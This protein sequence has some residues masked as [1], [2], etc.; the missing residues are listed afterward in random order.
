MIRLLHK[1][2]S[3]IRARIASA[4]PCPPQKIAPLPF[5]GTA[6][7]DAPARI[8]D[9]MAELNRAAPIYRPSK[10]W[11]DLNKINVDQLLGGGFDHFKRTLNQ[12]YFNWG[13][14]SFEDNQL[15][16]LLNHWHAAPGPTPVLAAIEGDHRMLNMFNQDMLDN[17]EKAR[18]YTFFVGLLW[19]YAAQNDPEKLTTRLAEPEI[20][21]PVHIRLGQNLISQDLA[22]S[23]REYNAIRE[24]GN[25][26][27]RKRMVV[28]EIGAGYGRVGYVFLKAT[29]CRYLIFD[30][31]P[32]LYISERYLS[33]TLP[34]KKVFRFRSFT[35]F[36]EIEKELEAAD[37][38]FFTPNQMPLFPPRYFD[39]SLS[40]SALHEMRREQI[41]NFLGMMGT[42]TKKVIY[43][44]NWT[45]WHNTSDDV[46]IDNATFRLPAPWRPT[47]ERTDAVQNMFTEK[48]WV[49]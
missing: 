5:T 42:L 11:T 49:R 33:T 39:I 46:V 4:L 3:R 10:F 12:N 20:G 24:F 18:I 23:I 21:N 37:V 26:D 1:I 34:D 28:A 15:R 48:V 9:M 41:D 30:V 16:N 31:P 2:Q 38:G 14:A 47:L 13:P 32:A 36:S 45:H 44:K 40:I 8:E 27:S 7:E 22:N 29:Q 35:R 43:L 19:W 25:T 17:P 6:P